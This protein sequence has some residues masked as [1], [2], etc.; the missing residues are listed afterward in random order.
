LKLESKKLLFFAL[1]GIVGGLVIGMTIGF[2]LSPILSG[3]VGG[4][5]IFFVAAILNSL[6][7]EV[8]FGK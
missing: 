5:A 7:G 1:V 4:I 8:W 2:N 3:V 6:W